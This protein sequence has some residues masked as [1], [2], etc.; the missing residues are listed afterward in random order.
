MPKTK[1][2]FLIKGHIWIDSEDFAIVRLVGSPAKNPSFWTRNI[3]IER[4]YRKYGQFWL[5][6][7]NSS[8]SRILIFGSSELMI[9]YFDYEINGVNQAH[10]S[11]KGADVTVKTQ[12]ISNP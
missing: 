3:K 9:D 5:P 6:R 10:D 12:L 4:Q 2:K 8:R 7:I 11:I 1:N